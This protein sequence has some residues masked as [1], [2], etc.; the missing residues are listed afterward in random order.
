M[1]HGE[2]T[3]GYH[4]VNVM[5]HAIT[6]HLLYFVGLI[7]FC[8]DKGMSLLAAL[9]FAVH[10]IHTDAID[11]IVGRAEALY[12]VFYL[13]SFLCYV[14]SASEKSTNWRWFALS[15]LCFVISVLSKEMG[16]MVLATNLGWD[17]L[18]NYNAWRAIFVKQLFPWILAQW[19]SRFGKKRE[20]ALLRK[21]KKLEAKANLNSNAST[22]NTDSPTCTPT[23]VPS[24]EMTSPEEKIPKGPGN[25]SKLRKRDWKQLGFRLLG[26]LGVGILYFVHRK[27]WVGGLA[28]LKMQIQHNPV[29]FSHGLEKWLSICYIHFRYI[30][31]LIYPI[32]LS[33]DYSMDCVPLIRSFSDPRNLWTLLTYALITA[34]LFFALRSKEHH[35]V[36]VFA[37]SWFAL[38]FL[39]A[40]QIF[41]QPGTVIAERVLYIPSIGFCFLLSWLLFWGLNRR[42]FTKDT[43]L[44]IC[45]ALLFIY[46]A[47]TIVRN[48]DWNNQLSLFESALHVCPRSGKVLYNYGAE[49]EM[50]LEE[51]VAEEAYMKSAAISISYTGSCGR[52]GKIWLK[53]GNYTKALSYYGL[54]I[55]RWP[56]IYHEFAWHDTGYIYW[57]LGNYSKAKAF[58]EF[59]ASITPP[60]DRYEGDAETNHGCMLMSLG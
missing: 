33:C 19:K 41:F 18:Y 38:P 16:V 60:Q 8:G 40:S 46:T 15:M 20:S 35:K 34:F 47:R 10:P 37:F 12:A 26:I 9:L 58:F 25:L 1:I 13:L 39:P 5:L 53:R 7:V 3:F 52:L 17:I 42:W 45:L 59:A 56:K 21:V 44:A 32:D 29:A 24:V 23:N 6:S 22:T 55:D 49:K 51:A 11:S 43:F 48:P 54:I 27:V 50:A 2:D 14:K 4:L 28:D 31:L 57:Q 30:W 36:L